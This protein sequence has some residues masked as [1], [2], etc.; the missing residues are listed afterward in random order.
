MSAANRY[1]KAFAFITPGVS[2]LELSELHLYA[3]GSRVDAAATLTSSAAPSS[4]S[5][6]NLKDDSTATGAYWSS[7]ADTLVLQ[8]QFAAPVAVDAVVVGS[9]TTANRFPS[10]F[11]LLGG[12][13]GTEW[14]YFRGVGGLPY[15]SA[16]KTVVWPA[17]D[18]HEVVRFRDGDFDFLTPGGIGRVPYDVKKEVL[19]A[20]VPPTY[21]P[22]RA[23]VRLER[24]IDGKVVREEWNDPVTG[25]GVFEGVDEN[26]TYTVTAIDPTENFRAV[27]ADRIKPEGYPT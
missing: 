8:W 26:F 5:L 15:V 10:A 7:G 9:Q 11:A 21:T 3:G 23:I 14:S 27:I 22:V 4:G 18:D 2:V 19:P 17:Y 16:T 1:W 20:T 25:E 12:P 24:D 13:D 6:A